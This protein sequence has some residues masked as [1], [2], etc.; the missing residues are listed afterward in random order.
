MIN[1]LHRVIIGA[2]ILLSM[3]IPAWHNQAIAPANKQVSFGDV[4]YS[5]PALFETSLA[6]GIGPTDTSMTLV[7]G[8]LRDGTTL[9]GNYCFTIDAGQTNTEYVCGTA[10]G[11][12]V[13]NLIRGIGADGVTSYSVLEYSH[14]YGA[15]VKITDFSNQQYSRILNGVGTFPNV[16]SYN[17]SSTT[18]FTLGQQIPDKAYVDSVALSGAPPASTSTGG[19]IIYATPAQTAAGTAT[20]SYSGFTFYLSPLN[21]SF[22]STPAAATMVPV[23]QS[24]GTLATGFINQAGSYSWTGPQTFASS[25]SFNASSTTTFNGSVTFPSIPPTISTSTFTTSDKG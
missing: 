24:N 13:T 10:S 16:L 9:S 11:T 25:T 1:F 2:G 18:Q 7:N 17:S 21:S 15:D 14:R 6:A 4:V 5:Q 8:T 12:S 23:T 22:G 20:S 19:T 3:I